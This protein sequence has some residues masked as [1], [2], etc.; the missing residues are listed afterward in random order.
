MRFLPSKN[1]NREHFQRAI[2][3]QHVRFDRIIGSCCEINVVFREYLPEEGF[4]GRAKATNGC[5]VKIRSGWI[6]FWVPRNFYPLEKSGFLGREGNPGSGGSKKKKQ[7]P[8]EMVF[9]PK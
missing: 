3:W 8:G 2:E 7:V 5:A 6:C 9:F 1:G 4:Y